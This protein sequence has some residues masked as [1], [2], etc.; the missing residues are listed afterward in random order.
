MLRESVAAM[1][2]T[3]CVIRT[4]TVA[5]RYDRWICA[6]SRTGLSCALFNIKYCLRGGNGNVFSYHVAVDMCCVNLDLDFVYCITCLN[7]YMYS[8]IHYYT[9]TKL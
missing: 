6:F 5:V 2:I 7:V 8:R 9:F 1:V 4:I 3:H